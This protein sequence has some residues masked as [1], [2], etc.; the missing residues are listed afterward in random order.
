MYSGSWSS[1]KSIYVKLILKLHHVEIPQHLKKMFTSSKKSRFPQPPIAHVS[2]WCHGTCKRRLLLC[3]LHPK[4]DNASTICNRSM[5]NFEAIYPLTIFVASSYY[6]SSFQKN[7]LWRIGQDYVFHCYLYRSVESFA[8]PMI[9]VLWLT[10]FHRTKYQAI[11]PRTIPTKVNIDFTSI[12]SPVK[13][14][15]LSEY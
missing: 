8:S 5:F 7:M 4:V 2:K 11:L 15:T 9:R 10:G 1:K 6:G 14:K 12:L 13:L 3:V